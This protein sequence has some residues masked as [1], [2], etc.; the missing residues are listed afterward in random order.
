MVKLSKSISAMIL[1]G[2]L[3]IAGMQSA[4]AQANF[5]DKPISIHVG[6]P[7]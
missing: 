3:G 7:P 6:F 2:V 1:A 4:L 5:P